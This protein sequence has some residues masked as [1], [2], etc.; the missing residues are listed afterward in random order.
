MATPHLNIF[1]G[2]FSAKVGGEDI[3][4]PTTG[5][6]NV[7]E[8]SKDNKVRAANFATSKNLIVKSRMFPHHNIHKFNWAS[9]NGKT[10][11]HIDNIL[12]YGGR[13]SNVRD[14]RSFE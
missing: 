11:S 7:H 6:E 4:R 5:N 14:V 10:Y 3:F 2:C 1:L 12:I 13:H 9:P 8:I